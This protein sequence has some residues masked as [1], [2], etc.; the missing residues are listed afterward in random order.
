MVA[1]EEFTLDPIGI[2]SSSSFTQKWGTPRQGALTPTATAVVTFFE[3]DPINIETRTSGRVAV[4]W[5]AHLNSSSFNNL[6]AHIKP[7][8]KLDGPVGVFATRG[9]HRPSSIGLTFCD[10]IA[11]DDK[12]ITLRGADM[13]QGTPIL[14]ITSV[15]QLVPETEVSVRMPAWTQVTPVRIRWSLSS[16]MSIQTHCDL[17]SAEELRGLIKN[18][19]GQDPRSHHS[20][21]KHVNPIYEVELTLGDGRSFWLVYQHAENEDVNVLLVTPGR[22]VDEF[23]GRTEQW[24]SKLLSKLPVL[25]HS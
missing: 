14:S 21:R 9:V 3:S 18:V 15:A 23:R 8:K 19:L 4:L 6:K 16:Y 25:K 24:L 10:K 11:N 20:K 12:S 5:A 17:S 2:V 1:L 13:I 7:P 22:I